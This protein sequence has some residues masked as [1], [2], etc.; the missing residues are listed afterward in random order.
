MWRASRCGAARSK[1]NG[2]D[3][4]SE[5][6]IGL[7][8][9]ASSTS[10]MRKGSSNIARLAVSQCKLRTRPP[11]ARRTPTLLRSLVTPSIVHITFF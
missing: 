7:T 2:A 3:G 6:F 8:L 5:S 9:S 10:R 4:T 1:L 11:A